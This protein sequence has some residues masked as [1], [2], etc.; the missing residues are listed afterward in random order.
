VVEASPEVLQR[1]GAAL[2]E[3]WRE[4]RLT[5][6]NDRKFSHGKEAVGQDEAGDEQEF[7]YHNPS[8]IFNN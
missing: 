2:L 7:N 4:L 5:S 6:L 1:A 8:I 3:G